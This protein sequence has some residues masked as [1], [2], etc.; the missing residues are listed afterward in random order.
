MYTHTRLFFNKVN[1]KDKPKLM[2]MPTCR[3]SVEMGWKEEIGGEIPLSNPIY[4]VFDF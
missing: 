2:K 1:K 4:M 3:K